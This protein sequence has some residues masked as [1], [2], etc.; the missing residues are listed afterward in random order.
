MLAVTATVSMTMFMMTNSGGPFPVNMPHSLAMHDA[1]QIAGMSNGPHPVLATAV[2]HASVNGDPPMDSD[3]MLDGNLP[4]FT[5]NIMGG[6]ESGTISF[7]D[8]NFEVAMDMFH[9]DMPFPIDI[10]FTLTG[11]VGTLNL[12]P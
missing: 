2:M 3:L 5:A 7:A 8:P 1:G 9:I 6:G 11:L 4:I 10:V 12:A